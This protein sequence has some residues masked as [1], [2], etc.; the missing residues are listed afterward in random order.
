[1]ND[2]FYIYRPMLDLLGK[3]EG[4]DKRRGY[5]ETLGYGAYTGGDRDLV[6]M[7]LD[8]ID[9]LQTAMLAHPKNKLNSS[10]LGRYQIVRTTL[11]K[12]KSS[13]KLVSTTRFDASLQDRLACY[14]MAGRG[15]DRWLASNMTLDAL[16]VALSKEWASLPTTSGRGYYY[17]QNAAV[18]VA[19]VRAALAE[20]KRRYDDEPIKLAPQGTNKTTAI[21]VVA[22][23]AGSTVAV[24]GGAAAGGV[25]VSPSSGAAWIII[26]T[27]AAVAVIVVGV[28]IWRRRK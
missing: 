3:S 22:A 4:T 21:G 24:V 1:M 25:A 10:A 23:A 15:F 18:T 12:L 7:T 14:L 17:G 9:Y 28:L 13:L 27:V 19:E 5:N 20:C 6:N 26:G 8:D 16:I 2:P 11:R